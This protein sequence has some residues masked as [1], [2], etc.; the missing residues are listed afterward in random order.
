MAKKR[1][2]TFLIILSGVFALA[3]LLATLTYNSS[4]NA[5]ADD[6]EIILERKSSDDNFSFKGPHIEYPDGETNINAGKLVIPLSLDNAVIDG[7]NGNG[8]N[9]ESCQTIYDAIIGHFVP[10]TQARLT[11][12]VYKGTDESKDNVALVRYDFVSFEK[13]T[14]VYETILSNSTSIKV[15]FDLRKLVKIPDPTTAFICYDELSTAKEPFDTKIGNFMGTY[16]GN[17]FGFPFEK[18]DDGAYMDITLSNVSFQNSYYADLKYCVFT[19]CDCGF[20]YGKYSGK[21]AGNIVSP[22]A[23]VVGILNEEKESGA[24]AGKSA[25]Y[26]DYAVKVLDGY[27]LKDVRV[28]YLVDLKDTPFAVMTEK[29]IKIPVYNYGV[30]VSDVTTALNL[31]TLILKYA[32]VDSF[33]Y[34]ENASNETHDEVYVAQYRDGIQLSA[35]TTDSG[36]NNNYYLDINLSYREYFSKLVTDGVI[37]AGLYKWFYNDILTRQY[38]GIKELELLPG[39]EGDL[40]GYFGFIMIPQTNS[41]EAVWG[42]LFNKNTTYSGTIHY[43]MNTTVLTISAYSK[44]LGEYQYSWLQRAWNN[45][46]GLVQN[47]NANIYIFYVDSAEN[48][49]LWIGENGAA[50]KDDNKGSLWGDVSDGATQVGDIIGNIWNNTVGAISKLSGGIAGTIVILAVVVGIIVLIRYKKGGKNRR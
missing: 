4:V 21:Y 12:T 39:Q 6:T 23:N 32:S 19:G 40:Y 20:N 17:K 50:D 29:K 7:Y 37:T 5:Y 33:V 47:Y 49:D 15:S 25:S 36:R 26:N 44:L 18:R 34:N 45:V 43:T 27:S 22:Y 3:F 24:L 31:D 2:T 11:L 10:N 35:K 1:R 14:R 46:T 9:T 30:L 28:R 16:K 42:D 48:G 8:L 41:I 38:P 13:Y